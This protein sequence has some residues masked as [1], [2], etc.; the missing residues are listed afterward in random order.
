MKF[1]KKVKRYCPYCKKHTIHT[2]EKAKKGKASELTWGQRQ[3]RRVT[4]GYGGFPRPKPEGR[5]KPV[6][7]IDLR[8]KCT[9][10][11]KMHTKASGCFRS[12]RFE[13]VEK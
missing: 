5:S 11:G 2:V 13:F 10:C 1:P 6:K 12:A 4:A 8:F 9:V 7:K 3:F